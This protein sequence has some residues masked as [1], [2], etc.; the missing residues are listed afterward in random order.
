MDISRFRY[1]IIACTLTVAACRGQAQ[2]QRPM[3]PGLWQIHIDSEINGKKPPD[4]AERMKNMS[5]ETRKRAEAAMKQQGVDASDSGGRKVCYGREMIE[6]GRWAEQPNGCKTDYSTRTPSLWK[7]HSS[8]PKMGFEGD[9]EAIFPDSE[10]YVV[11]SSG[12][13]TDEGKANTTRS[14]ITAKWLSADCGDIKPLEVK[15]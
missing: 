1:L 7:W 2:N 14:T 3:K 6:Q 10:N 9:G 12:V 15:R 4:M 13:I 5:P 11:K 8:C